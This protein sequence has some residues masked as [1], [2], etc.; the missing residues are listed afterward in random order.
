MCGGEGGVGKAESI[1]F[2]APSRLLVLAPFKLS[3][4]NDKGCGIGELLM[5]YCIGPCF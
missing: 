5:L 3:D 4:S 2:W 1:S